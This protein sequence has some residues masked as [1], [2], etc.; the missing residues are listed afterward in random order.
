M[1]LAIV[2]TLISSCAFAGDLPN[3]ELTPGATD[4]A[5]TQD[6]IHTTICVPNYTAGVRNVPEAIKSAIFDEY[7]IVP[8]RG[9][10]EIDHL[11]SLEIG[12]SNDV[13]NLWPQS[14]VTLP[15]NAHLKDRLENTLHRLVCSDK[16]TLIEAQKAIREDWTAAYRKYVENAR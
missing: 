13:S 14:Y 4:S 11:V 6:T 9:E 2:L 3:M 5:V 10:Y 7:G 8:K 1:K 15:W 12:G 16:I